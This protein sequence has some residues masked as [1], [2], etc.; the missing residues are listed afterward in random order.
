MDP[1][2]AKLV[3]MITGAASFIGTLVGA[4][5]TAVTNYFTARESREAQLHLDRERARRE[6]RAARVTPFLTLVHGRL[7]AYADVVAT[8]KHGD[9]NT[10]R[11]ALLRASESAAELMA[12][13]SV[14]PV[15][16]R[17]DSLASVLMKFMAAE[18][19]ARDAVKTLAASARISE[20]SVQVEPAHVDAVA[21]AQE[22]LSTAV[23]D[24]DD[25]VDDYIDGGRLRP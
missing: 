24:L 6:R 14:M 19:G 13:S 8:A 5:I 25:V 7:K 17:E 23:A 20:G 11:D 15:A 18:R 9:A 12:D 21:Q 4:S 10:F 22:R 1:E 3:A 16:R 2:T